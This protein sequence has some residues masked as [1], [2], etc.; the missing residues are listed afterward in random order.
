MLHKHHTYIIIPCI[1]VYRFTD[2]QTADGSPQH[3]YT[4]DLIKLLVFFFFNFFLWHWVDDARFALS[5]G[6]YKSA[7]NRNLPLLMQLFFFSL[8]SPLYVYII[9]FISTFFF[10]NSTFS[11]WHLVYGSMQQQFRLIACYFFSFFL[12]PRGIYDLLEWVRC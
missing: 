4:F 5:L 6:A 10:F 7:V 1:R 11:P 3:F 9:H 12:T 2:T 8:S